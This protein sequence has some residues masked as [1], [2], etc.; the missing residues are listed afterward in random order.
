MNLP[1]R[2]LFEGAQ[3]I[4]L[5][6]KITA[7]IHMF[8]HQTLRSRYLF[9]G[10]RICYAI[11]SIWCAKV[12]WNENW[13]WMFSNKEYLGR[14]RTRIRGFQPIWTEQLRD[15]DIPLV[16]KYLS[17]HAVTVS[18]IEPIGPTLED[19]FVAL[20]SRRDEPAGGEKG[21]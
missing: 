9:I 4:L 13:N 8:P 15:Q 12:L 14:K 17:E 19:V 2:I 1:S 16:R 7:P 5:D 21:Q 3:G 11:E 6:V 18:K 10:L 20:T